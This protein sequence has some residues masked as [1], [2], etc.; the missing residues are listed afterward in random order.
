[1]RHSD[2]RRRFTKKIIGRVIWILMLQEAVRTSNESNSN[3]IPNYQVQGDITKWSEETL[4]RTKF[5]RDTL[6]Q[7]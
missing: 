5:D 3:P 1:M 2:H 4:E 7:E 6:D